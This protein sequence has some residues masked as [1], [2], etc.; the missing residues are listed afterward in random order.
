MGEANPDFIGM[1]LRRVTPP[2]CFVV[3][4]PSGLSQH[5][6]KDVLGLLTHPLSATGPLTRVKP[7]GG[8]QELK[9][10]LAWVHDIGRVQGLLQ[11][12]DYIVANAHFPGQQVV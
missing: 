2:R 10:Q 4:I 12:L 3:P 5:D 11:G 6:I 8:V 9:A 1:G 7:V